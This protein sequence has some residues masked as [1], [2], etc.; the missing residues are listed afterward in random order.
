M[1]PPPPA[2][3][4]TP[5]LTFPSLHGA[6]ASQQLTP[7]QQ[8]QM[9]AQLQLFQALSRQ[10]M[11]APQLSAAA[12][13]QQ[14]QQQQQQ[15]QTQQ[16]TLEM[17]PRP[18]GQALLSSASLRP[19]GLDP[20]EMQVRREHH[21]AT[22]IAERI[23]ELS[24]IP[25]TA[26]KDVRI[27]AAIELK[28]LQLVG[29]QRS[30]R[31]QI[32]RTMQVDTTLETALDRAAYKRAKKLAVR[33]PKKTE[34]L[35]KQQ[36]AETERR[37]HAKHFERLNAILSHAQRFRDFHEAVHAKVQRIGRDLQLHN[38]RLEKQRKAESERLEK[39]RMRR[40]MEEDEEGYR[41][42]IDS[43]KDKR[44]SYLLNQT[45]EYIEKL[46]ALV[47]Q[48]QQNERTRGQTKKK[49]R[50]RK[51][52]QPTAAAAAATSTEPTP[53]ATD[54]TAAASSDTAAAAAEVQ[55]TAMEVDATPAASTNA[56]AATKPDE[57]DE[58]TSG[59]GED[60]DDDDDDANSDDEVNAYA[61]EHQ[62]DKS[63]FSLAHNIREPITEQP[64]M[65]EFGKLKEY[66]LKGLEWLVS[67]YNNNLN[68]ILADEMGLGKTI[69]TISLIAYLIEKKQMMGPYLVV[70]PLSVLSNWQLEFERW[71]PSIVKHVYKG[72]PAARRAL[73]PIIRGG[74]F[75]V[76]LTTYDYI[77]RDKNVLSR[78]AWKYVIVDE[79]HR[80]KNHSGKLNTV[81]TQYFPAPNRLLLSG[82]P[83]QNN[84]PEMWA[85][86]N[87]LLPTIFNSVDNF[88]QWFNA[89][90]ANTTEK[91]ELSGEESILIIR[92]LHKILRPFLL[93]RLK[94]EV[95]SQLPDKVEYVVKCGMSQLQKTMYSFVKRKGVLLTSAQDTDPSAAKKLQQKPTG[96]RVLAHTLMQLR[97]ICNHPFLFETLER[98]VSRHMGF[99]G[100]IIT[101]SLVVRASGK[102]E[103][104]DRLLTK[105]HRTGHRVLL[106]S[107]MTQCLTIL[108]DYCNYNNILYLRL[109]GNTKPDERAEL[110]TKFNA[111]NSP[112]N[113]FLLSTRAGGLGLNLQTADTVVIFDSDW[114]PH[115]DLQAQDRA[116]RIGQKNEVR[117]I[118]FVTAD[119]VEERML[120]A[121]QFKLDMDKK[122]I[123]AGKFDQKSTSSERRHLLEQLMDDSKEDDEE[124]AKDD[125][126][127]VH[128]DDTLN[129]MLARSEDELRIF[130]QLDKERQQAPAF[131]YPNGIHTTSR[132]M[133][134]NELPDWLLVD[135]EEIDRLVNDAPAVEYGR[136]QREHK[137]VLY[138]DGLTEGEFLDLV[139]DGQ[140]EDEL[141][142]R[143][144]KK[145]R[146][147][148]SAAASDEDGSTPARRNRVP[149]ARS[150]G[151]T[152]TAAAD[153]PNKRVR[154]EPVNI[155]PKFVA[156][157]RRLLDA[158]LEEKDEMGRPLADPFVRLPTRR[159]LPSYYALIKE[160]MDFNKIQKRLDQGG[161][162]SIDDLT[163]DVSLMISNAQHYNID[164]SQIFL[165][166]QVLFN[167]YT[168]AKAH[169]EGEPIEPYQLDAPAPTPSTSTP[170]SSTRRKAR[171]D[172]D[173][174]DD[175]DD[176]AEGDSR[177][178]S[179]NS[180]DD[181][182]TKTRATPGRRG[183]PRKS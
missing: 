183:R 49:R 63:S 154:T 142:D 139:E 78:V 37:R 132:L 77:V 162:K 100:A 44:L 105:L 17:P 19:L 36:R 18:H 84:L 108:E 148:D 10:R 174:D 22:S 149:S 85:L 173:D 60:D 147:E 81:L 38:E 152:P 31:Q 75:N 117:V 24:A 137:D 46:G 28:S 150:G 80:V 94:R 104:F 180:E 88:E 11:A 141:K 182:Y 62:G 179:E 25:V 144:T 5:A 175:D 114:N 169:L 39:E 127:S 26:P 16:R 106:F 68:G 133:E 64:T 47:Q 166:S 69:Q 83:L 125:E 74:K 120:A 20:V 34:L 93:R 168:K 13:Q 52:K 102:F 65:L 124:E 146:L 82:T 138:D 143:V 58:Y 121:A 32:T 29:L 140:L 135:D 131:D 1:M 30:L 48:H 35:E 53:M 55:P 110:L 4:Q 72:S 86:L 101:G 116:H 89:P 79:G 12:I 21:I 27:R 136:G 156:Q 8:A 177:F 126:S 92:R 155:N 50:R 9:R 178:E 70:V 170:T 43:E 130:Q 14:Q 181:E 161:Y 42:L 160:P 98:G 54:A 61:A 56:A 51:P 163:K 157:L 122:V 76:L 172:E 158:M 128:D 7:E 151:A 96:V 103:M 164:T 66:Q 67:L 73:H 95:E 176:D 87:F 2:G 171:Y 3:P 165:D 134:E 97:K 153:M 91:V 109:D 33:E 159:E 15:T 6:L 113:L 59:S 123:Q 119:S 118:R 111:P 167:V 41:K 99:G 145:R 45:D 129:Q 23:R 57:D 115:Q 40:L 71:A 90:F 112:Y 107:Q